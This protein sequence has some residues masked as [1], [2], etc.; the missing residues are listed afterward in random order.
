MTAGRAPDAHRPDRHG[1][2]DA[3]ALGRTLA[4]EP[5]ASPTRRV[6][7]QWPDSTADVDFRTAVEHASGQPAGATTMAFERVLPVL[8]EAGVWQDDTERQLFEV[9]PRAW[10][11]G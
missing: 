7:E 3:G 6:A 9:N 10:R 5:C 11:A 2:I 1:E 4:H 8:R